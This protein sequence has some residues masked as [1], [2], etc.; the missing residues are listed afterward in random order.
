MQLELYLSADEVE[1]L[2]TGGFITMIL[3]DGIRITVQKDE[4]DREKI[5]E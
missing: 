5:D 3:H 1:R 2:N 4:T